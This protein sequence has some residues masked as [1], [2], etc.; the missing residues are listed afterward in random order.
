MTMNRV[1]VA[2]SAYIVSS[3]LV[4]LLGC[5]FL[6]YPGA[7]I[8]VV[9]RIVGAVILA[10][11]IVKIYGYFS[12]DLYRIAFQ[13]DLALGILT[14]LLGGAMLIFPSRFSAFLSVIISVFVIVDSVFT[15]QNSLEAKAFGIKR[16]WL[17]LTVGI[18]TAAVGGVALI[19]PFES[20]LIIMR[21]IGV[22]F[23][24]DSIQNIIV[25][26]LTVHYGKKHI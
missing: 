14:V 26:I 3:A 16:W 4:F 9:C 8:D 24:A 13:F 11:G 1:K 25:A 22:A 7:S 12:H 15:I 10:A 2:K 19:K 23:I 21:L 20:S 6:F 17:L 18:L 5:M